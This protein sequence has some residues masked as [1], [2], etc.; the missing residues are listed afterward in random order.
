[1]RHENSALHKTLFDEHKQQQQ[2]EKNEF[3][4]DWQDAP[5]APGLPMYLG[6]VDDGT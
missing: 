1:M 6:I 2:H 4:G 3:T 5:A